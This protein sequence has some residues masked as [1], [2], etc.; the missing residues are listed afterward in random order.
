MTATQK[1]QIENMRCGGKSYSAIAS[2][3]GISENTV[4]SHCRRNGLGGTA[5]AGSDAYTDYPI[6]CIQC[7]ML[8]VQTKG[9]KAKRFCSDKCRSAWW[10]AH[11]DK[12]GS[13]REFVCRTC[14]KTFKS[15]GKRERK[16]CSR[17]CYGQSKM[18]RP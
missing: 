2:A 8:L 3:L 17:S 7:G 9:A 15:N 6:Y 5:R 12:L 18:V 14:G 13:A 4:K 10:N 16:Y 11:P 1:M